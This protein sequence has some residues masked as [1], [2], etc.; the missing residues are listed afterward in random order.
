MRR[1]APPPTLGGQKR[2]ATPVESQVKR[3]RN[4]AMTPI[5]PRSKPGAPRSATKAT[6]AALQDLSP[7]EQ[8]AF[9]ELFQ[10][11]PGKTIAAL[12]EILTKRRA[13]QQKDRKECEAKLM[14]WEFE[15]GNNCYLT[16]VRTTEEEHQ[17]EMD[18]GESKHQAALDSV[19][20][21][22]EKELGALNQKGEEQMNH[23]KSAPAR[24]AARVEQIE[25]LIAENKAKQDANMRKTEERKEEQRQL[26]ARREQI[27]V[28][29]AQE[30]AAL[31]DVESSVVDTLEAALR[32]RS[33]AKNLRN[34]DAHLKNEQIRQKENLNKS[35][36]AR[37]VLHN[38]REELKGN[39]RVYCRFRPPDDSG[40]EQADYTIDRENVTIKGKERAAVSKESRIDEFAFKYDRVFGTDGSNEDIF[41]AVHPMIQS[42]LD[43]YKVCI[44]AYGQT[45]SGKTYTMEGVP[46]NLGVIPRAVD[47][48]FDTTRYLRRERGFTAEM[49]CSFM[50]IYNDQVRD[51]LSQSNK[52]PESLK[53]R[54]KGTKDVEVE[55]LTLVP[56]RDQRALQ[57]I[58]ELA[59]K[60]RAC[61][62]TSMN[63]RS[64]RSHSIFQL[65]VKTHNP[66]T[67]MKM[68]GL[69]NLIDLAGSERVAKSGV[70][71]DR[72]KEAQNIN[73][74]L[75][76][77]GLAIAAL[78]NKDAHVPYRNST[79]T[80]ILKPSLGG[81]SKCLMLVNCSPYKDNAEE[82]VCSLRFAQRVN[83]TKVGQA[84][85]QLAD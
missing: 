83:E 80:H 18:E 72:M 46:S 35:E 57:S 27:C 40:M 1:Q 78:S 52:G 17:K 33:K 8:Q 67:D 56:V 47:M 77:L 50:E 22:L 74:S 20:Q 12:S 65:R 81:S 26:K 70:T 41:K 6:P 68:D 53:V 58:L 69:L 61:A 32:D 24:C 19:G 16:A 39:I 21:S 37:R 25:A 28:E 82:T 54:D 55:G 76:N 48:I 38:Q 15:L 29:R 10:A 36:D 71:G 60:N 2:S 11:Y 4:D 30:E 14:K 45:G 64:S 9:D 75:S 23:L 5:Q 63:A 66:T 85:R 13:E 7:E 34:E 3:G 73:R 44:F 59:Q 31:R 62:A 51:L 42:C 49:S 79:L 84:K 43:G